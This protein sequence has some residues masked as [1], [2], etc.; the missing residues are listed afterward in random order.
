MNGKEVVTVI[1][2]NYNNPFILESIDSVL[3]QTYPSVQYIIIDD[4]SPSGFD[5]DDI[6]RYIALNQRGNIIDCI[7]KRNEKNLGIPRTSNLA[8][9]YAKGKY[10]FNLAGDDVFYDENVLSDWVEE[11]K[12]SDAEII[13]AYQAIYDNT[14][15]TEQGIWPLESHVSLLKRG[16]N[17]DLFEALTK[18]NFISGSVTARTRSI[19]NKYQGFDESFSYVED[20]PWNLRV[21]RNKEKIVFW[22]RKV[23]KYRSGGISTPGRFNWKYLKDTWHV[24]R[25]EIRQYTRHPAKACYYNIHWILKRIYDGYWL[26]VRHEMKIWLLKLLRR[27]GYK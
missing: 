13:T 11:F 8:L 5:C 22:D 7:V 12:R 17:R 27:R 14:L 19:A 26:P 1:T 18:E 10:L 3:G 6:Y 24:Y 16:S 23:I 15:S 21:L 20:Y 2:L 25:K 9:K 4:C